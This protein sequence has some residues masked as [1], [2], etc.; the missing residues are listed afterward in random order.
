MKQKYKVFINGK[1]ILFLPQTGENELAGDIIPDYLHPDEIYSRVVES[2]ESN[3]VVPCKNVDK[4]FLSFTG[5]FRLIEAAGG[6]VTRPGENSEIL[7]IFRHGKWDL[8]KGKIDDH[9]L[10]RQSALREVKEEC[11]I[12]GLQITGELQSSLHLYEITNEV[13]IKKTYWYLMQSDDQNQPI[14]QLNEGIEEVR[15][16]SRDQIA[17]LIPKSYRLISEV[18]GDYL[19]GL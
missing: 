11:G 18:I 16:V 8:P 4:S 13:V 3:F 7:M 5:N 15:W 2:A 17:D 9:E 12:D 14:P 1:E 19:S 10:P 6:L